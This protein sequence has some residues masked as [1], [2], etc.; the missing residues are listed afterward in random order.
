M[1]GIAP[2]TRSFARRRSAA[3]SRLDLRPRGCLQLAHGRRGYARVGPRSCQ[4]PG[5][6]SREPPSALPTIRAVD[7]GGNSFVRT[8]RPEPNAMQVTLQQDRGKGILGGRSECSAHEPVVP[9]LDPSWEVQTETLPG[10]LDP[11][12]GIPGSPDLSRSLPCACRTVMNRECK[13][14][15]Y[16]RTDPGSRAGRHVPRVWMGLDLLRVDRGYVDR[17]PRGEARL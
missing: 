1:P 6:G 8:R 10:R 5:S 3:V 12:L 15:H 9:Q 4:H 16:G 17:D 13:D 2:R 11:L 7:R 14:N